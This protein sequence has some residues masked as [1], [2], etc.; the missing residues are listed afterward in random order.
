VHLTARELDV[1]A[2]LWD[3]GSATVAEVLEAMGEDLA[4]TTVL[5]VLRGLE[6]KGAVRHETD[7]RAYRYRAQIEASVI[8]DRSL[9]RLLDR[10]Y[11]GSRELLLTQLVADRNVSAAELKR[12]RRLIDERLR[13]VRR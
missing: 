12:L 9:R 8:G 7:G 4:Y 10:V 2:V 13:E 6:A 11:A 5:T 1:V 3:R